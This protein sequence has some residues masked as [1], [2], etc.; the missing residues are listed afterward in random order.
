M[1]TVAIHI[2]LLT[3]LCEIADIQPLQHTELKM[4]MRPLELSHVETM[5]GEEKRI[6]DFLKAVL[7]QMSDGGG[8][9][10]IVVKK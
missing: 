4:G 7:S 8:E 6:R 3:E 2:S 1:C 10:V 5:R 9:G